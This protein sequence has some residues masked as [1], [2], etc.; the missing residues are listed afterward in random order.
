MRQGF[1]VPLLLSLFLPAA[2][3]G[4]T[5]ARLSP[6]PAPHA[7]RSLDMSIV[8]QPGYSAA[9]PLQG[10][11]LTEKELSTDS[12]FGVGLVKMHGRKKDGSDMRAGADP[13]ITR[14]PALTFVVK[15]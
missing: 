6:R 11:K 12:Y 15:F 10:G 5:V 7:N 13:V 1:A 3:Q 14:N 2:G 8:E 4:Q 9:D